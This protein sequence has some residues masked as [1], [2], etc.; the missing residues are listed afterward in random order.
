[1]KRGETVHQK[2]GPHGKPS[3]VQ[4]QR[5][6]D[7]GDPGATGGALGV[8]A[9]RDINGHRQQQNKFHF[10]LRFFNQ[11]IFQSK[12][13]NFLP[14]SAR[15]LHFNYAYYFLARLQLCLLLSCNCVLN[16]INGINGKGLHC[17]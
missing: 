3:G 12:I 10:F 1:M 13:Q 4:A 9:I 6:V 17:T 5:G 8:Q 14:R 15:Q 16:V 7:Q 11:L 2:G